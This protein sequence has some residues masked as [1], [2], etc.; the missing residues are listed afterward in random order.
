MVGTVGAVESKVNVQPV[1][2]DTLVAVSVRVMLPVYNLSVKVD[3]VFDQPTDVTTH[4]YVV[5]PNVRL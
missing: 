1:A 3:I 2:L 5:P 4:V